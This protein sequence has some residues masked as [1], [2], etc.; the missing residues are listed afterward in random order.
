VKSYLEM[1]K[2]KGEAKKLKISDPP[3]F[4]ATNSKINELIKRLG[5]LRLSPL[6]NEQLA[7]SKISEESIQKKPERKPEPPAQDVMDSTDSL[8]GMFDEPNTVSTEPPTSEPPKE[9]TASKVIAPF[10]NFTNPSSWTGKTPIQIL[11]EW[12]RKTHY[13]NVKITFFSVRTKRGFRAGLNIVATDRQTDNLLYTCKVEEEACHTEREAQHYAAVS[14]SFFTCLSNF[15]ASDACVISLVRLSFVSLLT[16]S[17][18]GLV[19]RV[20]KEKGAI[21]NLT[22]KNKV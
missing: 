8:F 22:H 19:A 16:P 1:E 9:D 17:L 7:I 13:K 10:R 20:E 3:A 4:K 21:H 18:Q 11:Q 2:L 12:Y 14:C 6:F 5:Q 15:I